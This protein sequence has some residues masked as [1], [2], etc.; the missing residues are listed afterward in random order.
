[1]TL[2]WNSSLNSL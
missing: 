2:C 1:M